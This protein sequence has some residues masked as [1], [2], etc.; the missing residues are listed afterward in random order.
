VE[1]IRDMSSEFNDPGFIYDFKT[2]KGDNIYVSRLYE[3]QYLRRRQALTKITNILLNTNFLIVL[4]VD[5]FDRK[6]L[7]SVNDF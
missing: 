2:S 3:K 6:H 1:Y 4:V 5:R 7:V